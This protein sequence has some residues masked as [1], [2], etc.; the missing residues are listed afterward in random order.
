MS[1]RKILVAIDRPPVTP[2]VFEQA[3]EL[4]KKD[5]AKLMVL[6]CARGE[7]VGYAT[8][9]VTDSIAGTGL[10]SGAGAGFSSLGVGDLQMIQ[11][12]QEQFQNE[13]E[14]DQE[15]LQTY[16]QK[17]A[18]QGVA[19]ESDQEV[20]NPGSHIC[21]LAR[22]WGAD[23]IVIGRRGLTGLQEIFLGSVSNHV[24]HHAPCSVLIVQGEPL[25]HSTSP[26]E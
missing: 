24:I 22:D 10:Y 4:A 17:A 3:L 20:G 19:A 1:Y 5:G 26:V 9:L 23:L 6:H 7:G 16:C 18:E 15:W 14:Q 8:P 21:D 12:Q 13:I 2:E 11:F 25:P